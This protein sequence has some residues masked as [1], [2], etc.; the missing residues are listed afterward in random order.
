MRK[1]LLL[2]SAIVLVDTSFYAA[3]T[4]LLPDLT[5]QFGLSKTGAGVLAAAYPVGTFVGGLPGGWMA[6]RVGV[7]PTVLLGLALMTVA[8]VAFAFADDVLV[9][10]VARF[11]QGVGGAASWAGAMGWIAG[12]APRDKRGQM[13]GSAMGA[14]IAGALFGPVIGVL[15]DVAGFE[16]VF[17][18]VGAVGLGLIVWT[19]RTPAAAPLGDGSLR[20]LVRSLGNPQVRIG[21]ALVTVPGLL[22]GTVSVLGPLR[23]DELGAGAAAI[24]ATWLLAAGLEA[25]VSPLAGRF[26]DRRG[27]L[28][29]LL[30]GLVGGAVTFSL[31]PWPS[32]AFGLALL[33]VL[34][35]PV[36]GLL[37]APAMA[38]L[39]DGADAAGLEQG[40]AFG[41]MNLT[42]ATGQTLGDIGGARLGEV[43]GDEV[44]Y[45]LLAAMCLA[46]FAVLRTTSVGRPAT[47]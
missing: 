19:L 41:L 34:G 17:C 16:L 14:A 38:M 11:V 30:G 23:M 31:L 24:G 46:S 35:C 33:I 37:W 12:A 40:L 28:A 21:L 25:I 29:P 8:S 42:W 3:I 10:D 4:P 32:T 9:L 45:L 47:V 26:S 1:L 22:F 7:R 43:A 15:A 5:D 27:R 18:A 36:I 2:A 13:I 44:A 6:A 20:G 39:S